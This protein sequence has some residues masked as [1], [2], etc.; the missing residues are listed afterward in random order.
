MFVFVECR[1]SG[2]RTILDLGLLLLLGKWPFGPIYFVLS[3]FVKIST[4]QA[5]VAENFRPFLGCFLNPPFLCCAGNRTAFM[6]L[7]L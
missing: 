1:P 7:L 3:S 5:L 6:K 2:S 4:V